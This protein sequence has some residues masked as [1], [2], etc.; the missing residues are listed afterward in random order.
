MWQKGQLGWVS[1]SSALFVVFEAGRPGSNVLASGT[2][3]VGVGVAGGF[4]SFEEAM[5]VEIF[6]VK[7]VVMLFEY[8]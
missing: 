6:V 5:V 2:M 7:S 1:L 4:L 3:E 8:S